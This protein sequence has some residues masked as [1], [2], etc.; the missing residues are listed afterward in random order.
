[1]KITRIAVV[2]LL[3]ISLVSRLAC[4]G[5]VLKM[6]TGIR[7]PLVLAGFIICL[8]VLGSFL[9]SGFVSA[10]ENLEATGEIA[11][12]YSESTPFQI[13]VGEMVQG[14]IVLRKEGL[15]LSI[16][17]YTGQIIHDFG[18][19]STRCGFYY[20]AA[21]DSQHYLV[22]TNPD[23]F[24]I[25]TR[26][27]HIY[28]TITPTDLA[29]GTGSGQAYTGDVTPNPWPTILLITGIIVFLGLVL[30]FARSRREEIVDVIWYRRLRR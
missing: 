27:Y 5:E 17:D 1:M 24:A 16:A 19:C 26:G 10:Q 28:Y 8:S 3:C 13:K 21:T 9:A 7:K 20:A 4:G 30:L 18:L 2:L 11:G 6:N 15:R 14:E 25:G 23:A 22:V 12:G 29:P